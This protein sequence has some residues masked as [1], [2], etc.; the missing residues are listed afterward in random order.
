MEQLAQPSHGLQVAREATLNDRPII[1][2]L[3]QVR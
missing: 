2:I 3:S 1:G